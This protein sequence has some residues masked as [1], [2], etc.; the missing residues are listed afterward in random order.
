V[1]AGEA[2]SR[3]YPPPPL[4]FTEIPPPPAGF[5]VVNENPA[6]QEA[7]PEEKPMGFIDSM[8][9]MIS[10]DP[11]VNTVT[12]FAKDMGSTAYEIF[13]RMQK[14][15]PYTPALIK[16]PEQKPDWLKPEGTAQEVGA[17]LSTV[18]QFAAPSA[19]AAKI[20][21]TAAMGIAARA[22]LEGAL[23]GGVSTAR[24]NDASTAFHDALMTG[25]VTAALGLAAKLGP[26]GGEWVERTLLK[27][28]KADLKDVKGPPEQAAQTMVK[29]IY[30]YDLGGTLP[31]SY[32]KAQALTKDLGTKLE[33]ALK[34][35]PAAKVDV[36]QTL[37]DAASELKTAAPSNWGAN[38]PQKKV[39]DELLTELQDIAPNGVV[40]LVKAQQMKQAMGFMGSWQNGLRDADST[41]REEVANAVYTKL[42]TAI[43]NAS[44]QSQAVKDINQQFSEII[45]I[46]NALIRRIPVAG[47]RDIIGLKQAIG[48]ATGGT[49]GLLLAG[50]DQVLRSGTFANALVQ[51][52][53]TPAASAAKVAPL[54]PS[55]MDRFRSSMNPNP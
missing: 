5:S 25:G 3:Q 6:P 8:K 26:A 14:Q 29:N 53:K 28:V 30:K 22:G 16:M 45:P 10:H 42:K 23:T 36:L 41:A 33:T 18:A 32:E 27:P 47:R 38:S 24:G 43:E 13:K 20:P 39:V 54:I 50:A 4:G 34:A 52:G 40:D 48:L 46:K 31:Q 37:A 17:A 11:A 12:G 55:A 21:A 49:G 51:A 15:N 9:A 44:G 2:M 35:N 7:P 1:G 19:M